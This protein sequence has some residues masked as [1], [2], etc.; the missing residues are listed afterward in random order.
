M[1]DIHYNSVS[2][3]GEYDIIISATLAV[4]ASGGMNT[5]LTVRQG[6]PHHYQTIR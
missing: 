6:Q 1:R 2:Q 5:V 3:L 4:L